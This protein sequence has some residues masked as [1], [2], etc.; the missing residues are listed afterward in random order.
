MK[1][2]LLF[3]TLF[4]TVQ[5]FAQII[6]IIPDP[7]FEQ[8]LIDR[9]HDTSLNGWVLTGS[10]TGITTLD[11]SFENISNLTGI[12]NFVSLQTLYANHN[13][14]TSVNISN[15]GN[16]QWVRFDHNQLTSITLGNH[17][18]LH[19]LE[20]HENDLASID[21]S[22]LPALETVYLR[23]NNLSSINTSNNSLLETISASENNMALTSLD[24]SNNP[25]LQY[26]F[27]TENNVSD[28]GIDTN[29]ALKQLYCNNNPLGTLDLRHA[30]MLETLNCANTQLTYLN[31]K[32]GSNTLM[33]QSFDF[34]ATGNPNLSCIQVDN[35]IYS[36]ATWALV[37]NTVSFGEHCYDTYVPDDNFEQ[38]LIDLGYDTTL[39]D[40][41]E[42]GVAETITSLNV[43][44][45]GISDMTGLQDM[46]NLTSLGCFGNGLNS[47]DLSGNTKLQSLNA[48]GNNFSSI[49]FSA[50][51]QLISFNI[52][53]SNI[54]SLD[55]SN[56]LL[57][58][59]V[60]CQNN[61]I[62]G[63]LDLSMLSNLR[64]LFTGTNNLTYL[65]VKNGNNTNMTTFSAGSNPNLLC[66]EVDDEVYS[67][68]NWTNVGSQTSFNENGC[69]ARLAPKAFLQGAMINPNTGEEGL[70]RDD[71]R[72]ADLIPTMSPY[73]D[74]AI[75]DPTLFVTTGNNAI[76]DWVFLELRDA[77][78][79]TLI[80]D[81]QSALLQRDG[82]LVDT[83][84]NA[85]LRF[86]TGVDDYFIVIKHR[87][88]LP[89]MTANTS[90]LTDVITTAINFSLASN[91]ITH[92][93][94]AQ[95]TFGVPSGA[96]AM[97]AG[98][99]NDDGEIVFL[100]TGAES[101]NIKQTVLDVST[102]ESPFGASVFYKPS[103]YYVDDV[104]MDGEV[105]F[106]NAG[107]ELL[108]IKDNIL[109][110]PENQ[111]FNSVFYKIAQQL[112]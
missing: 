82:D 76:V 34:T 21:L 108:Y 70:M 66:V 24:F 111:I 65:N 22:G 71:L 19:Q 50:N 61:D 59:D 85:I 56:N 40:Y 41:L 33:D 18:S 49:D 51:T 63:T 80:I 7:N 74:G 39:N 73:S 11:V 75:C 23:A 45:Q 81:G 93:S 60:R 78:D 72:V 42:D 112:P 54:T 53:G 47:I 104:N 2:I 92:G 32:N 55:L 86:Y 13:D 87:N 38:R 10:I 28:L 96:L 1:K 98:D 100:N 101:V 99:V 94:N 83:D 103:G 95:T 6:T 20:L 91:E 16:L 110:H 36:T 79:N 43:S 105:V 57:L 46:I 3:A 44:N 97:W 15:L 106:L 58:E 64:V 4:F 35:A 9:G 12:Q 68:A 102:A 109:A 107:N 5:I 26:L 37:D 88:H 30:P 67:T 52:G 31:V 29:T 89:I 48:F 17:P 27:C 77:N 14:L 69:E 84:G 90:P 25:N 62:T 8:A